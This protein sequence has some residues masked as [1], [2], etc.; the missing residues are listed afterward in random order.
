[1]VK[2]RL[3][4]LL[5]ITSKKNYEQIKKSK[6]FLS[7][8]HN[9]SG[10]KIQWLGNGIYFW[11][12]NDD[13]AILTGK[14]LV[15]GKFKC[16]KLVGIVVPVEVVLNRHLDLENEY[17]NQLYIKFLKTYFPKIYEKLIDY[18]NIIKYMKKVD[19]ANLNKIGELTGDTID[20][21]LKVLKN[22]KFEFDMVSGYFLH[23]QSDH[24]I[25]NRNSKMIRQFC[26]KNE[27]LVNNIAEK[28]IIN[29]NI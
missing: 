25:F 5:H 28:W 20:F 15:K 3:Y 18:L 10:N 19:T 6:K 22:Q 24:L 29:Y 16:S 14:N 21:F 17:W 27:E 23:G 13:L 26:V 12:S 8:V 7:S 9:V 1:M 11:D 2:K 4:T